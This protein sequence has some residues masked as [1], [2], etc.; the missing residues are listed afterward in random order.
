MLQKMSLGGLWI[1]LVSLLVMVEW[2]KLKSTT[3]KRQIIVIKSRIKFSIKTEINIPLTINQM[4]IPEGGKVY[5]VA[6]S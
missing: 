5:Q 2:R 4:V 1:S 3:F 6:V